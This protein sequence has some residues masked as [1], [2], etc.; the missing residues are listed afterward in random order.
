LGVD[1]NVTVG[2][3]PQKQQQRVHPTP[4]TARAAQQPDP[5]MCSSTAY[6]VKISLVVAVLVAPSSCADRP[7]HLIPG[8]NGPLPRPVTAPGAEWV[9]DGKT[10]NGTARRQLQVTVKEPGTSVTSGGDVQNVGGSTFANYL[11]LDTDE[12]ESAVVASTKGIPVTQSVVVLTTSGGSPV[13]VVRDFRPRTF[14]ALPPEVTLA[15]SSP[16]LSAEQRGRRGDG[17]HDRLHC[18]V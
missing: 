7:L 18:F 11:V 9:A 6:A 13:S 1:G 16:G 10:A 2:R 5:R 8:Y 15:F 3:M 12:D 17:M 14:T 4:G